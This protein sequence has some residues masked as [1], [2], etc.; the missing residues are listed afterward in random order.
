MSTDPPTRSRIVKHL[1]GIPFL[2]LT[3]FVIALLI[4]TFLAQAFFVDGASMNPVLVHGDRVLV[5]KVSYLLHDPRP[6]DV[7]VFEKSVFSDPAE[8]PWHQDLLTLFKE[9]IGLHTGPGQ[10]Y[11]KRV[12]AGPGDTIRY[13]GTPPQ[14]VVDGE[15]VEEPYLQD[16]ADAFGG[17]LTSSDCERLEMEA[18]AEG[19][20][21]PTGEIFVMGDNRGN[22]DDSRALGPVSID[23][24][25]GR[26]FVVLWPLSDLQIL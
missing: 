13:E 26:A 9:L 7:V 12:V 21:V 15:P 24:V 22:S 8:L 25:I 16:A 19:C 17:S 11:I 20:L 5:E 14:L 1:T 3:A 18:V 23:K 10:D 4:K 2:L 6:G